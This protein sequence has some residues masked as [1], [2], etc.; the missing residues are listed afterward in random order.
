MSSPLFSTSLCCSVVRDMC[1]DN[2]PCELCS[3]GIIPSNEMPGF[4]IFW[5]WDQIL[6]CLRVQ[7]LLLTCNMH[8]TLCLLWMKIQFT[9]SAIDHFVDVTCS[10]SETCN[11][12]HSVYE[13]KERV[14]PERHWRNEEAE[15]VSQTARWFISVVFTKLD[16]ELRG[17]KYTCVQCIIQS[18]IKKLMPKLHL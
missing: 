12:V 2:L 7:P 5:Q 15:S 13:Q 17:L 3:I 16:H 8:V 18:V 14:H 4:C 1:L 11:W 9:S 10:D 6:C